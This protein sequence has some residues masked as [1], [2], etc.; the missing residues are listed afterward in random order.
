LEIQPNAA[1]ILGYRGL[2]YLRLE[3]PETAIS[4]YSAALETEPKNAEYLY[5]RGEARIRN[6]DVEGGKD[7][8][9]AA[10]A[11][12]P[13]VGEEFAKLERDESS[14]SWAAMLEYWR[15]VMKAIY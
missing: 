6:G 15:A 9:A 7:D 14:W 10:R 8:I 12:N 2:V 11:I 13:K 5:G 1:H 3:L 4:D